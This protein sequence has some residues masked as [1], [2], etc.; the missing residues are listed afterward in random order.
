MALNLVNSDTIKVTQANN[1]IKL[2]TINEGNLENLTTTDKTNLVSAINEVNG[3]DTYS[4]NEIAIGTWVDGKTIYRKTITLG[5]VGTTEKGF[6]AGISNLKEVV[7]MQGMVQWSGY[8]LPV[9]FIN[10]TENR[11]T[12][13]FYMPNDDTIRAKCDF[14]NTTKAYCTLEYT[15]NI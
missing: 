2:D 6:K 12:Y 15:K 13:M 9:G 1:N 3:K 4:T 11:T 5:V 7:S 8:W 14:G 10:T